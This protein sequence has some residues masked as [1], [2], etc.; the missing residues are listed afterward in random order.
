MLGHRLTVPL[1]QSEGTC[2]NKAKRPC[3]N[4]ARLPQLPVVR[5]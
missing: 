4:S 3:V 2:N 5:Q 1:L